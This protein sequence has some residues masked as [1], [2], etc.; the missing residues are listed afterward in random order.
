MKWIPGRQNSGY[1]KLKLL[2]TRNADC[3]LIRYPTGTGVWFHTDEVAGRRHY[4]L[5]VLIRKPKEG[6]AFRLLGRPLLAFWR[7]CLFRPDRYA[8]AVETVNRGE[9]WVFS[10]GVAK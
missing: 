1:L 10:V 7:V 2:Q 4:R 3:Y 5:N 6:G 9:R 8:H